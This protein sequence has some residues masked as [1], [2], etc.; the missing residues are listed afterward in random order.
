M[1]PFDVPVV[2]TDPNHPATWSVLATKDAEKTVNADNLRDM[3]TDTY[4]WRPAEDDDRQ[5]DDEFRVSMTNI[6]LTVIYGNDEIRRRKMLLHHVENMAQQ[7]AP[8]GSETLIRIRRPRNRT[9]LDIKVT[10]EPIDA[11]NPSPTT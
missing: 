2:C 9:G 6:A 11:A 10:F 3:L 5:S 7:F 8:L 4:F 1:H